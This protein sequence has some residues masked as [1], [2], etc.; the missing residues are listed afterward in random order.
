MASYK[1]VPN[2]WRIVAR[3]DPSDQR[4]GRMCRLSAWDACASCSTPAANHPRNFKTLTPE[5]QEHRNTSSVCPPGK[6]VKCVRGRLIVVV[7]RGNPTGVAS[8]GLCLH[9]SSSRVDV[10]VHQRLTQRGCS[11]NSKSIDC[12]GTVA[13]YGPGIADSTEQPGRH[14][15]CVTWRSRANGEGSVTGTRCSC[16]EVVLSWRPRKEGDRSGQHLIRMDAA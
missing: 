5:P 16:H 4:K 15:Y 13:R 1:V 12:P 3:A 10:P 6:Q 9:A 2:A 7:Q 14:S 8:V 11:T